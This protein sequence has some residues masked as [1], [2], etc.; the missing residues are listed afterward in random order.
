MGFLDKLKGK[1]S[2]TV[3]EGIEKTVDKA[4]DLGKEGFDKT[5]DT[6]EKGID[7]AKDTVEK[8]IDK[9]KSE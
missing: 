1:A 4:T 9:A 2:G 6:V 5:K 3:K 8:G 7:E